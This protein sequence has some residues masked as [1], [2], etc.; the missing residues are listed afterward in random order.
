MSEFTSSFLEPPPLEVKLTLGLGKTLLNPYYRYFAKSLNLHGNEQV[1]DFGSGSGICSRH[2]AELLKKGGHLDCVD[3]S[4]VWYQ[5]IQKTLKNFN[6]V[7]FYLGHLGQLHLP[8]NAYDLIVI[9][10]VLHDIPCE[11]RS[12]IIKMLSSLIKPGG[13]LIIREPQNHGLVLEE[14]VKYTN[15]TQLKST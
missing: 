10:F 4:H 12:G 15:N 8:E 13:R 9:H 5:V 14:I 11:L 1:L 6:N 7:N 3:I 2:I